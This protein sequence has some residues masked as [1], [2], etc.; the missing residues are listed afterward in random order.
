MSWTDERVETLK[1]LWTDGLSA[2]QI[3]AEL[4]GITRKQTLTIAITTAGVVNE[5]PLAWR[6][7]EKTERIREGVVQDPAFYGRI[8]GAEKGDD[9]TSENTWIKANPSLK[10][11]G[12]FVDLAKIRERYQSSL[13]DPEAQRAFKKEADSHKVLVIFTDGEDH[14][15]NPVESAKAAAK[16]SL[17]SGRPTSAR[18]FH[19]VGSA[20]KPPPIERSS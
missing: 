5:S 11:R 15:G 17:L 12:G 8:Y 4:G 6:L 1:K 14:E 10:E 7:H 20:S 3:A 18:D 9:W 13:S 2:S 19:Q 16:Q